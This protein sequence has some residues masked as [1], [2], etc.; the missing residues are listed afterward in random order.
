MH[1][2]IGHASG[3][4]APGFK[5]SPQQ[6]I[7]E[8]FSALEEGRADLVGLYFIGDPKLVELG[9]VPA[10]DQDAIARTEYEGYTRNGLVQLRRVRQGSQIE[11]DHM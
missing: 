5:G 6:S 8:Y 11:D 3:Q 4:Q 9:I 10:A 1:E 2:V 7:K